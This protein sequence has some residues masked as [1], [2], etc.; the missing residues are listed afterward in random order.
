MYPAS[1]RGTSGGRFVRSPASSKRHCHCWAVPW[2]TRLPRCRD[3][4]SGHPRE[5][6]AWAGDGRA[7]SQARW[8]CL[9]NR[10]P[11]PPVSVSGTAPSPS[12]QGL[13][14]GSAARRPQQPSSPSL[15]SHLLGLLSLPD[16]VRSELPAELTGHQV[17]AVLVTTT[18]DSFNFLK[19][20]Y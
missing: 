5:T 1:S 9:G 3:R 2:V 20:F 6:K 4:W 7:G 19:R 18:T 15:L 13:C 12:P 8:A 14:R 17:T 11:P 10:P 16:R